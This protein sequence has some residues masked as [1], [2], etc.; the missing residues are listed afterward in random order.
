[1]CGKTL[2]TVVNSTQSYELYV[3]IGILQGEVLSPC[4]F[5]H[6]NDIPDSMTSRALSLY[7]VDTKIFKDHLSYRSLKLLKAKK[8]GN[9]RAEYFDRS[10]RKQYLHCPAE[11]PSLG[12]KPVHFLLEASFS[13]WQQGYCRPSGVS[14]EESFICT[15]LILQP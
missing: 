11:F 8:R 7:S 10:G 9:K 14:S 2:V 5:M 15:S 4:L 1:M 3:S 6:T 13:H 12:N